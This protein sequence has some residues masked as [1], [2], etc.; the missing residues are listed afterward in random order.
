MENHDPCGD[1]YVQ[2]ICAALHIDPNLL[3]GLIQEVASK[4]MPLV[5]KQ[6]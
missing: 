5:A 1:T 4:S 6:Q 3:V 2:T